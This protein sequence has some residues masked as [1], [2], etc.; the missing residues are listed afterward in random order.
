VAVVDAIVA[1]AA[2]RLRGTSLFG[3]LSPGDL[4]DLAR[5]CDHVAL[6]AGATLVEAGEKSD[7]FYIVEA[8]R[9][10]A[11]RRRPDGSD[12]VVGDI[13]AGEHLG[14]AAVL[15]WVVQDTT[16]TAVTECRLFALSHDR[17]TEFA[18]QHRNIGD[19]LRAVEDR[20]RASATQRL[21]PEHPE[22]VSALSTFLGGLDDAALAMI[23]DELEWVTTPA[24][25][26]LMAQGEPADCLWIVVSGR[27]AVTCRRDDGSEVRVDETGPG[28][29]LGEMA[30]LSSEPR[31]ASATAM[32]DT[33]LLRLSQ[34]GFERLLAEHPS[35][36]RSFTT[37]VV[38][39]LNQ[40]LRKRS[41]VTHVRF[42]PL[43]S[44][45]ECDEVVRT[46]NLVL[47]NLRITQMYHRLS[48]ELTLLLGNHDANWC[49]YACN[50]SKTAGYS[51]RREEVPLHA[52]VELLRQD[53]RIAAA[54]ERLQ[55]LVGSTTVGR[56]T[57][58]ALAD[59]SR[60]I[61]AGNLKVFAELAPIFADFTRAFH[62]DHAPDA[63]KLGRFLDTL[64][65][66]P[67]EAGGQDTLASALQHYY[68]AMFETR[69]K[70]KAEL[71][72]LGNLEVGL[73]EQIRLQPHIA[74]AMD[75]PM[76][77]G[78]RVVLGSDLDRR[79]PWLPP[80]AADRL[81]RA[82]LHEEEV[83]VQWIA[84]AWRRRVTRNLMTLRLP[85]GTVRLGADVP[86]RPDNRM[87]PDV[88]QEITV[89]EL[90]A[91]IDR[92]DRVSDTSA[93]SRAS[94][95]ANLDDRMSFIIELMRSRQTS[96]EL[97]D[98]PFLHA[99]RDAIAAG[100]VPTGRL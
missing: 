18:E 79:V 32:V 23:E 68:A 26:M 98:Q 80:A 56:W 42:M 17:F 19:S 50:A 21:R 100:T 78:M 99:Q 61:S 90:A 45:A 65:P 67:T 95:W 29:S 93:G 40:S 64:A 94:D 20:L 54:F 16:V 44:R 97:F 6:P 49:T 63:A 83:L 85:Y 59:V 77:A 74:A 12:V 76:R 30:L 87:Y 66:G 33:E 1:E 82:V 38:D 71:I 46:E 22:I 96:L 53:R 8:G 10:R 62:E 72:L 60:T 92:Y 28:E 55:G 7:T 36:M 9:L 69:T 51:I 37:L 41:L 52:V 88:L 24:G 39:R 91:F 14:D 11:T 57:E 13:H 25:T 2:R 35:A 4:E 43:V 47:R 81:R 27:V 5:A 3:E 70:E 31:S 58:D 15:G 48:L 75:A 34:V 89:P 86:R 73:H 84:R